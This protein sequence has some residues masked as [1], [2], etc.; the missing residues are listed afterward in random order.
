[1][2][3]PLSRHWTAADVRALTREDRPWPRDELIDGELIVTPAPRG[4]QQMAASDILVLLHAFLERLDVGFALLSP[5]DLELRPGTITQPDVFVV[6]TGSERWEREPQWS[7]I[8][9]LLL[10]IEILSPGSL[11]ADRV[12]KREFYLANGVAEYWIVDLDA[13]MIER[14]TPFREAPEL[15]RDQIAWAPRNGEPLV[16]NLVAMFARIGEKWRRMPK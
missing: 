6:P 5:A 12:V 3:M 15:C 1:M 16:I 11:H 8:R 2:A 9:S 10:A 14:W 13:P 7:D 4:A